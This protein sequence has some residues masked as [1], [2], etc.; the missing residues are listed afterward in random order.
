MA[1]ESVPQRTEGAE[2]GLQFGLPRFAPGVSAAEM[3][4]TQRQFFQ[5]QRDAIVGPGSVS[6][7]A[8]PPEEG[9]DLGSAAGSAV[10]GGAA[11][12]PGGEKVGI[13]PGAFQ[14]GNGNFLGGGPGAFQ[15]GGMMNFPRALDSP[16]RAGNFGGNFAGGSNFLGGG[17][18]AGTTSSA[19]EASD[20]ACADRPEE[21]SGGEVH[22]FDNFFRGEDPE[23]EI[24]FRYCNIY[25]VRC[26]CQI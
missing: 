19:A 5:Q 3:L 18:A 10:A 13:V 12:M 1:S 16:P 26:C 11:G 2:S 23:Q 25:F 6:A 20:A 17:F 22:L 24:F 4:A 14:P 8:A 21:Q 7:P 15:P 9:N